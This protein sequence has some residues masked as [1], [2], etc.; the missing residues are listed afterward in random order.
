MSSIIEHTPQKNTIMEDFIKIEEYL[1]NNSDNNI[2]KRHKSP[3]CGILV[4]VCGLAVLVLSLRC[5]MSD[6]LTM[7]LLTLGAIA[8]L[9]GMFMAIMA[10]TN[11][12]KYI[13]VPTGSCL[14]HYRRYINADDRNMLREMITSGNLSK[15]SSVRK[16][17]STGTLL[18]IY[19]SQDGAYA[20]LQLEEYIPHDFVPITPA[21][22]FRNSDAAAILAFV[23]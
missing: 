8:A 2:E 14:K 10:A 13:Y 15:L 20:L 18:Q 23:K 6:T 19:V 3:L 9:T 12:M 22:A 11:G 16:E 1:N 21:T 17:N 5:K 4:M 7:T